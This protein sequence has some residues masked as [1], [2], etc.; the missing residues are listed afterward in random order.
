[1]LI[2]NAKVSTDDRNLDLKFDALLYARIIQPVLLPIRTLLIALRNPMLPRWVPLLLWLAVGYLVCPLDAKPDFLA[3]GFSDDL[4]VSPLLIFAA[5]L[6]IPRRILK[7]SK[8][9][10]AGVTCSLF[11]LALAGSSIIWD[12]IA[13]PKGIEEFSKRTSVNS[14]PFRMTGSLLSEQG[15]IPKTGQA[16]SPKKIIFSRPE[17]WK[18]SHSPGL[19]ERDPVR[20]D[21]RIQ[22]TVSI[23]GLT[24]FR[25]GH[26]Q[27]YATGD[28]DSD[29]SFGMVHGNRQVSRPLELSGGLFCLIPAYNSALQPV[30]IAFRL[31]MNNIVRFGGRICLVLLASICIAVA[32]PREAHAQ[33]GKAHDLPDI[34]EPMVFDLVRPLGAEKGEC[35]VNSLFSIPLTGRQKKFFWAPETEYVLGRGYAIEPQ[36]LFQNGEFQG[37][38]FSGQKT[39]GTF[40]KNNAIHGALLRAEYIRPEQQLSSDAAY[41]CGARLNKRWSFFGIPGLRRL[42]YS[43]GGRFVTLLNASLFYH[44]RDNLVLGLENNLELTRHHNRILVTPQV[45]WTFTKNTQLQYGLGFE[46]SQGESPRLSAIWRVVRQV[47]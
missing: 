26:L 33:L 21:R 42:G 35:E 11:C 23:P 2:G 47:R 18:V 46:Q 16:S 4:I 25:A 3:G 17:D 5:I 30:R 12:E 19:H 43:R 14:A 34:P 29:A 10:A 38:Q 24:A 32:I 8:G 31:Y 13:P 20:T 1:M 39:F 37:F 9:M 15:T 7:E 45:H 28:D 6:S 41:L 36:L 27:L 44:L 22:S 40:W